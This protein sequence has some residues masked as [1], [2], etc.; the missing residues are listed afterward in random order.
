VWTI[1]L[2]GGVNCAPHLDPSFYAEKFS[3]PYV[4][5]TIEGRIGHNRPQ[6]VP[7]EF[8]NAVIDVGNH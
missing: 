4:H 1:T 6:E 5:R 3:G 2:E 7:Q 8:A